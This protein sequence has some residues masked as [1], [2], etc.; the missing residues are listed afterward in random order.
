MEAARAG[1]T[2]KG[3][4]VVAQ[5]IEHWQQKAGKASKKTAGL[6]EKCLNGISGAKEYAVADFWR[7]LKILLMIPKKIAGA[8]KEISKDNEIQTKMQIILNVKLKIYQ[9]SCRQ[10]QQQQNRRL[11]LQRFYPVRQYHLKK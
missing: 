6:I 11:R 1:D 5:E 3:F 7:H 2:G 10:I 9:M 4:A 8:F